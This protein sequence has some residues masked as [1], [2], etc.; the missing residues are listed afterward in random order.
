MAHFQ[1]VQP[2]HNTAEN[3]KAP[4][5][6]PSDLAATRYVL[7]H[8]DGHIPPLTPLYDGPYLVLQRSLRTFRIQVG[9]RQETVSTQRLKAVADDPGTE[10]AQPR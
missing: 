5:Q 10:P 9:R 1:P 3:R 6:L 4:V 7:V 8:R 2:A